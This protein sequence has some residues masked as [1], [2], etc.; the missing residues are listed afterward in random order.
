MNKQLFL[1]I[2]LLYSLILLVNGITDGCGQEVDPNTSCVVRTPPITCNTYN[3]YNSSNDLLVND[4]GMEEIVTGTGVYNFT[5]I[6]PDL[7]VH[8]LVL[9]DNTSTNINVET[10][11][12]TDL[13]TILANQ[14]IIQNS[15]D[16]IN[17]SV[18]YIELL[19]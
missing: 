9:C 2:L 19:I 18:Y 16:V 17:E 4:G 10:T 3:H 1:C 12:Q 6:A 5:F 13:G 14:I 7:G 15:L 11:D 8:T